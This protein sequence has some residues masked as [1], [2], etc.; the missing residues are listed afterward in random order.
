MLHDVVLLRRDGRRRLRA[1][2]LREVPMRGDVA[3]D[4]GLSWVGKLATL[5]AAGAVL[6]SMDHVSL[7]RIASSSMI[8][9]GS[10]EI[11]GLRQ[12]QE[13]WCRPVSG[14]PPRPYDPDPPSAVTRDL[15]YAPGPSPDWMP[16]CGG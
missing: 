10:E 3:V 6:A 13:W 1:D 8:I 4:E 2:V 5:T 7:T 16:A 12:Q 11:D 9:L 15:S 14:G